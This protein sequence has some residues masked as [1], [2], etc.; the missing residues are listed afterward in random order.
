MRLWRISR[1]PG[2]S[3]IGGTFSNGRWHHAPRH[4]LYAA[5]HPALAL[6]EVLAHLRADLD[7]MP[8]SLRLLAIDVRHQVLAAHVGAARSR[9]TGYVAPIRGPTALR[10]A[11][12][13]KLGPSI[14]PATRAVRPTPMLDFNVR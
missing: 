2:L 13:C 12:P 4:V 3:G 6:A 7:L 9:R 11:T 5:E 10:C 1:Y 14:D 8:T